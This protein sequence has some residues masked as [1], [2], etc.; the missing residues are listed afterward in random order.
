MGSILGPLF[1]DFVPEYL[2]FMLLG[3]L[4]LIMLIVEAGLEVEIDL[5]KSIGPRGLVLGLIGSLLPLVLGIGV[6]YCLG[7]PFESAFAIGACVAPT[8]MVIDLSTKSKS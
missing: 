7:L 4:G 6:G 1:V 5:M 3:E 2:A 8:S